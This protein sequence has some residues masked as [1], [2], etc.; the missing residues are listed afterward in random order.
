M[1]SLKKKFIKAKLISDSKSKDWIK[2]STE[3]INKWKII[4]LG[5]IAIS[6]LITMITSILNILF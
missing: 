6:S 3:V 2:N 1:E 5:I 4:F